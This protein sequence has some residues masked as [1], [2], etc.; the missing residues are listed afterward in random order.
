MNRLG[1]IEHQGPAQNVKIGT[2]HGPSFLVFQKVQFFGA[3]FPLLTKFPICKGHLL[4]IQFF[5]LQR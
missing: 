2:F 1:G 4:N 5:T 3:D